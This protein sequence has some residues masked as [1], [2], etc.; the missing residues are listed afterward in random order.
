MRIAPCGHP[1][2][3]LGGIVLVCS[4]DCDVEPQ[5]PRCCRCGSNTIRKY[6]FGSD[7]HGQWHNANMPGAMKCD[8]CGH[9]TH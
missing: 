7:A 9:V 1:A 6:S 4:I 8:N 2:K 5:P 3:L